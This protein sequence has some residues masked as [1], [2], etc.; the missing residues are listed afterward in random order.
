MDLE[1]GVIFNRILPLSVYSMRN[2]HERIIKGLWHLYGKNRET[3]RCA[4]G[5]EITH[6]CLWPEWLTAH[7]AD[8]TE[9][10]EGLSNTDTV[11]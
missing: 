5:M 7:L 1:G 9:N 11:A 8:M 6:G 4:L 3:C 2:N 10:H